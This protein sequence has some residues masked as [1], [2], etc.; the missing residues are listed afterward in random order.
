MSCAVSVSVG[1]GVGGESRNANHMGGVGGGRDS[2]SNSG[3]VMDHMDEGAGEGEE[4]E[5]LEED[6][7]RSNGHFTGAAPLDHFKQ[8]LFSK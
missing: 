2:N 5:E 3:S 4:G 1:G 6:G 7:R 8:V